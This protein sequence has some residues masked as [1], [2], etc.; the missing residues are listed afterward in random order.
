MKT[1]PE[2]FQTP[3]LPTKIRNN[4]GGH[5]N[6]TFYW[7]CM[8]QNH[9]DRI[10]PK[11]LERA[12]TEAF[13]SIDAFK[14]RFRTAGIGC[15][16]SGYVWL[17]L[18]DGKLEIGTTPNQDNPLMVGVELQGKPLLAA[19]VWEHAYYLRYLNMRMDYLGSFWNVVNWKKVD[20][21]MFE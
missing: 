16:G 11:R 5:W 3:G 13:G 9:Q 7:E 4:A 12:L 14:E 8:S 17:V 1:L 15:F 10:M 21:R 6:H 18:K 2:M 19:D 20:E